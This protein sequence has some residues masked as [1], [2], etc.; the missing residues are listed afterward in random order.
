MR[1]EGRVKINAHS[2]VLC[3]LHPFR[4][5]LRLNLISVGKFAVLK[6]SIACVKIELLLARNKRKSLIEISHELFRSCCLSRIVSRCLNSAGE[7][8]L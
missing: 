8:L 1:K 2:P 6:Y 4:E 3:E 7:C 5:V